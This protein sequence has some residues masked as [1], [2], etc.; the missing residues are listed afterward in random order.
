VLRRP[1]IS[2]SPPE[3]EF[4]ASTAPDLT[5]ARRCVR[6]FVTEHVHGVPQR[7]AVFNYDNYMKRS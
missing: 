4:G 7:L 6:P 3:R 1:A 5:I 2:G